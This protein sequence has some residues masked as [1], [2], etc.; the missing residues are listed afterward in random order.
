MDK[1]LRNPKSIYKRPDIVE[2]L[3]AD[4]THN[5]K[6]VRVAA[7]IMPVDDFDE[8]NSKQEEVYKHMKTNHIKRC[9]NILAAKQWPA[10]SGKGYELCIISEYCEGESLDKEIRR[11]AACTPPEK[12]SED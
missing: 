7:K 8:L 10:R 1:I 9:V 12:F 4:Y 3:V 5:N 6:N 11:R 2:V